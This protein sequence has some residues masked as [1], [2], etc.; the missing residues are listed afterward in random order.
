MALKIRLLSI[1]CFECS[2]S[3][4]RRIIFIVYELDSPDHVS[5]PA[6]NRS[7]SGDLG[8]IHVPNTA[9]TCEQSH[10][11]QGHGAVLV[12]LT[13]GPTFL[14]LLFHFS[15]L[16]VD[17]VR[18]QELSHVGAS[19]MLWIPIAPGKWWGS[20]KAGLLVL[21]K[22]EHGQLQSQGWNSEFLGW[23]K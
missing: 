3:D 17:C 21:I 11:P 7:W 23:H 4:P 10:P 19:M 13:S 14:H 6:G 15:Y 18:W 22:L 5:P 2:K 1:R 8:L 9:L 20:L 16:L 12:S